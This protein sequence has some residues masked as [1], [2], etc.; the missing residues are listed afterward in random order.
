MQIWAGAALFSQRRRMLQSRPERCIMEKYINLLTDYGFKKVFGEEPNKDLLISFLNSLLPAKHQIADLEYSRSE[1][2][3]VSV[4]ER[5]AVMDLHC[6][7][8]DG[9]SFIVEVQKAKQNW[10][11]DRSVYYASFPIQQQAVQGGSWDYRLSAVYSIGVLDFVFDDDDKQDVLHTVKLKNQHNAVFY[12]KLTFIY[13]TLPNFNKTLNELDS[14]LE[15][16]LYLFRNLPKLQ[17]MPP[18]WHEIVF[19]K[20]FQIA[21]VVKL[22]PDER[23]AYENSLKIYRDMKNVTDTAFDEGFAEGKESG[24]AEGA[25][26]KAVEVA[27]AAI[28]MGLADAQIAALSGLAVE[29]IAGLREA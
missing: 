29:Q 5:R 26:Q 27:R 19:N 15:R 3:G 21:E 7:A 12:D 14:V 17:E 25:Q 24:I 18:R 6:R 13:L 10:F 4:A 28:A 22:P 16:W 8:Q 9:T 23:L 11:K 1:W 2:Q 20:L